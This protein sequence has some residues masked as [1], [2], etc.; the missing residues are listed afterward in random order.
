M[1][2][3]DLR[4]LSCNRSCS[5]KYVMPWIYSILVNHSRHV[6]SQELATQMLNSLFKVNV[7]KGIVSIIADILTLFFALSFASPVFM[8]RI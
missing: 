4:L 1:L 6:I 3:L 8:L 7:A 5:A 2:Y